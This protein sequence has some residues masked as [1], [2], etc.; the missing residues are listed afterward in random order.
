MQAVQSCCATIFEPRTHFPAGSGLSYL[1]WPPRLLGA[2]SGPTPTWGGGQQGDAG[3]TPEPCA[4]AP[5]TALT[6]LLVSF[7][8]CLC[9]LFFPTC[10]ARHYLSW[11]MIVC[12][13]HVG[14]FV[15][16]RRDPYQTRALVTSASNGLTNV[17]G[18]LGS[19]QQC[20]ALPPS[21]PCGSPHLGVGCSSR[22][23]QGMSLCW[24]Q[25]PRGGLEVILL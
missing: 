3:C 5:H 19:K 22:A 1:F 10:V 15:S 21:E 23:A 4:P 20:E 8:T 9:V 2:A 14:L 18:C 13:C 25:Q 12:L 17:N 6:A 16:P 11:L 7:C 24:V